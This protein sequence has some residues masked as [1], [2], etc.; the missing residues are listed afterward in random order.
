MIAPMFAIALL[1]LSAKLKLVL[2]SVSNQYL[3]TC[4][5]FSERNVDI[6]TQ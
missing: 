2:L 3:N 6:H 5:A 4:T 1:I